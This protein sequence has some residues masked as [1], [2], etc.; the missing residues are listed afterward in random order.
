VEA[1]SAPGIL[2][3]KIQ[4]GTHPPVHPQKI[5]L[6]KAEDDDEDNY[7]LE[8]N[9]K[10]TSNM[11]TSSAT[12]KEQAKSLIFNVLSILSTGRIWHY[13]TVHED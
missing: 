3:Y 12:E 5:E 11:E 6:W 2:H 8:T 13:W 9:E 4:E 7:I 10:P 1:P